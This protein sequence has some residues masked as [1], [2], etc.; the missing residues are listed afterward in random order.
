MLKVMVLPEK[1]EDLVSAMTIAAGQNPDAQEVVQF[2]QDEA[3]FFETEDSRY[4][5]PFLSKKRFEEERTKYAIHG[6]VPENPNWL[7][8]GELQ[9][10][11]VSQADSYEEYLEFVRDVREQTSNFWKL[12]L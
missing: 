6:D 10:Y 7:V 4:A 1:K 12:R 11:L 3:E 2:F 8:D 9:A 5:P